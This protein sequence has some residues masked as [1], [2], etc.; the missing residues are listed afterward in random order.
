MM[1]FQGFSNYLKRLEKKFDKVYIFNGS[2]R[3]R[4]LAILA[5]IRSIYQYPLFTSKD[6]IFQTA[7]FY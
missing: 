4:L 6:V 3:Y 5:G 1:E 2:L 7:R